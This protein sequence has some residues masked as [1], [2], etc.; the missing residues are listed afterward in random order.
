M[1]F[2]EVFLTIVTR[3]GKIVWKH[4]SHRLFY[5]LIPFFSTVQQNVKKSEK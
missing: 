5:T 2:C 4:G 1:D 3:D